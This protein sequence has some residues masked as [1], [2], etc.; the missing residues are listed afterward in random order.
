MKPWLRHLPA[1]LGQIE[2]GGFLMAHWDGTA[3]TEEAI[4]AETKAT[5]R[6]I[7]LLSAEHAGQCGGCRQRTQPPIHA[8]LRGKPFGSSI[9]GGPGQRRG[10]RDARKQERTAV[11][12]DRKLRTAFGTVRGT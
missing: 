3:E 5:I 2:R 1:V 10:Q 12:I 11:R 7:P 6:C 8:L 4:K 9:G